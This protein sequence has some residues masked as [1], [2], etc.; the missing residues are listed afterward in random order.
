MPLLT[1]SD[2]G[3]ENNGIANGHTLLRHLQDPSLSTTLQHIFK[4]S[5]RNIKPEIF[6]SQLRRRWSP[7][8]EALLNYGVN[9]GLYNADDS[10]EWYFI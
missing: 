1:Q 10:L 6:W 9:E 4:G 3:T 5:H 7:G 2:P 8:F